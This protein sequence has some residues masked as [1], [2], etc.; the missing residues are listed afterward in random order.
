MSDSF[1]IHGGK[2]LNGEIR[3]GGSKNAAFPLIAACLLTDEPCVLE[4]V[5]YIQDVVVMTEMA[6]KL[7]VR[8]QWDR[9]KRELAID[10]KN[11]SSCSPDAELSRK[12]RGSIVFAGALLGRLRRVEM[13]Y[14][15][16][17]AIGAR[18]LTAHFRAFEELGA[19]VREGEVIEIDGSALAGKS[20]YMEESSATGT[21]NA[22]LASALAPGKT[23]IALADLAPPVQETIRFLRAMGADI[24]LQD[25][26]IEINGVRRLHGVRY[27][28]NPDE[29]EISSFAALAAATRSEILLRGIAPQYLDPVF[30]QLQKMGVAFEHDADTMRIMRPVSGYK[31]FRIQSG[32]YPKLMPDHVPQFAALATQAEGTSLVHD[33]MYENRQ[34]YIPELQKMGATCRI[35]DPHRALITGPAVLAGC[36]VESFDLRAGMVLVIAALVADGRSIISNV[37][38]IDRGYENLETRLRQVGADIKRLVQNDEA[39]P[40]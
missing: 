38:H 30:L 2:P 15:G 19:T 23:I 33:W 39:K 6:G 18:P 35:L 9:E 17:D 4:N 7:G 31:S 1:I 24:R 12:L 21:E 11:L 36:D 40:K 28:I 25:L 37:N 10:A 34:R 14:P 3:I 8:I 22:L 20:F 29:I 32:L 27:R 26:H 5:P 16:G 13:P